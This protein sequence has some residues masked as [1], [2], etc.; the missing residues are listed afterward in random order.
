LS[1]PSQFTGQNWLIVP[2]SPL[3]ASGDHSNQKWLLTLTGV[4]I[5]NLHGNSTRQDSSDSI[6]ERVEI[7]PDIQSPLTFALNTYGIPHPGSSQR[8]V[9]FF[10]LDP[11]CA[12]LAIVNSAFSVVEAVPNPRIGAGISVDSLETVTETATDV[13]GN[14]VTSLF[15]GVAA[16]VRAR[17]FTQINRVSYFFTLLG[18]IVFLKE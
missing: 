2:A 12:P 9:P 10:N 18:Q 4:H 13:F 5:I 15:S 1:A 17:N 7:L 8:A 16:A 14:T 6:T 11:G 3:S